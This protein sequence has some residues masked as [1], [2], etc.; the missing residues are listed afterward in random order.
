[1]V[2]TST[3]FAKSLCLYNRGST[4]L[5]TTVECALITKFV[6]FLTG[7]SVFS[8]VS[9]PDPV[10]VLDEVTRIDTTAT[11]TTT[12]TTTNISRATSTSA[13]IPK[14]S[15]AP[16]ATAAV[17][18]PSKPVNT[19]E[20]SPSVTK[21][22]PMAKTKK[23]NPKDVEFKDIKDIPHDLLCSVAECFDQLQ[24]VCRI[25]FFESN[26]VLLVKK[27]KKT[28]G[29]D[30]DHI[31]WKPIRVIPKSPLCMHMSSIHYNRIPIPPLP[32]H[33][34]QTSTPFVVCK[35]NNH[36][37][38]FA[39]SRGTNPW[40]PHTAEELVIWT[41]ERET[42]RSALVHASLCSYSFFVKCFFIVL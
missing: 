33:M 9:S 36:S 18:S 6:C 1:M 23:Y 24:L 25:C 37:S 12:T 27:N 5:C 34:R 13:H 39:M 31:P 42:G 11:T 30:K 19:R 20:V 15:P 28:T 17:K 14:L 21:K 41:V 2:H 7:S 16:A 10:P 35:K 38:C 3:F 32:K 29:C 8:P 40:F 4:L 22:Q 26:C